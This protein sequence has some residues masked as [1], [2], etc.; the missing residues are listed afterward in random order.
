MPAL[1]E[2]DMP[3]APADAEDTPAVPADADAAPPPQSA[4]EEDLLTSDAIPQPVCFV[5]QA[6]QPLDSPVPYMG[7]ILLL[8]EGMCAGLFLTPTDYAHAGPTANTATAVACLTPHIHRWW[9]APPRGN[10]PVPRALH[11]RH[12]GVLVR[13]APHRVHA[14]AR[15]RPHGL[16][17]NGL[18]HAAPELPGR[19]DVG[20]HPRRQGMPHHPLLQRETVP[21]RCFACTRFCDTSHVTRC[22]WRAPNTRLGLQRCGWRAPISILARANSSVGAR[23]VTS[24][25]AKSSFGARQVQF[26]RAK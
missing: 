11:G 16:D 9:L 5:S 10:R 2:E 12:G 3:E 14:G 25:R 7:D 4:A 6:A 18:L 1:Q 13:C 17:G 22:I 24:W 21:A 26:G 20:P 23:R 19:R 15:R 8:Q